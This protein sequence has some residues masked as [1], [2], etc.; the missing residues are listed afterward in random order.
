MNGNAVDAEVQAKDP[1]HSVMKR[2]IV[3]SVATVQQS[4]IDIEE[5]SLCGFP[6]EARLYVDRRALLRAN[7]DSTCPS[8]LKFRTRYGR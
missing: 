4:A 1:L 6:V 5:I 7:F 2:K 3:N 8:S